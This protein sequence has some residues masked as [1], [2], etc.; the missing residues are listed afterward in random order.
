MLGKIISINGNI[1]ELSL[2]VDITKFKNLVNYHVIFEDGDYKIVG[3][4]RDVSLDKVHVTLIG[5]IQD[6]IYISGVTRKPSFEASCRIISKEELDIILG[7]NEAQSKK[8]LPIGVMPLYGDYPIKVDVN[9]FFSNHFVLIG[10]TGSGKSFALTRIL[11]NVLYDKDLVPTNAHMFVFDT[12]GEYHNAFTKVTEHSPNLNYKTYTTKL[13]FPEGELLCIPLWLLSVDDIALLLE[14]TNHLQL[15]LIEK[16]LRLVSVFAK[17]ETQVIAYKN[18]IIARAI[19]EILYSGSSPSQ[20]RDQVF[21]VLTTFNTKDLSLETK[22]SQPGY[23]RTLR[24]CFNIDRDGK[25][26]EMQLV[27]EFIAGFTKA[28][29]ELS[30]PDGSFPYTLEN[31]SEALD[32]ALISEGIL[33]SDKVYDYANVLK[34]RLRSLISSDSHA[35]FTYDKFVSREQY[36]KQLLTT[37]DGK[38]AQLVNFDINYIDDRLAKI[39]TKIYSKMLYEYVATLDKRTSFPIHIVLEEAHRYVQNDN[40]NFLLGYN[41]FD[42]IAKEGRKFGIILGL[43][44][45][46]PSELSETSL[47]QCS[48]FVIFKTLHPVDLDFIKR[49]VPN[50]TDEIIEKLKILQSGMA[51]A[52]GVAFKIPIIIKFDLPDPTPESN[53]A[54]IGDTWYKTDNNPQQTSTF[55]TIQPIE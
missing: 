49:M 6:N 47:S 31:L 48:N 30:L 10:N 46:R 14:A 1:A 27:T 28:D 45:Q 37:A 5:E 26:L 43:I 11:Q 42:R 2:Q 8:C 13:N 20:I 35:F 52:F 18:D 29:L 36:I 53:N 16:A 54:N 9:Q 23:I 55:D 39:I 22:L 19:L 17:E 3:E 41:I 38:K 21:A 50:M 24:Q 7:A 33:K 25:L 4:I 12:Y 40:D 44:S 51:I 15:P 34:V 32:F